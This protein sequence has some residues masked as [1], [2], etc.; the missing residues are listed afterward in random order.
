M[1]D[2][3][4]SYACSRISELESL[5]LV[6]VPETVW[7]KEMGLA[8]SLLENACDLRTRRKVGVTGHAKKV[9]KK[10]CSTTESV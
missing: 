3:L 5:L 6:D 10:L 4:I 2:S 9:C 8:F 7:F 1:T